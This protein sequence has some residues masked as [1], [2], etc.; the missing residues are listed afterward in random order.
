M[1]LF[2]T[3][4]SGLITARIA[5]NTTSNNIS[6]VYTP[7]YNRELTLV[8]EQRGDGGVRVSDVQRQFNQYVAAQLN[9]A[10]STHAALTGY[11]TQVNQINNLLADESVGL[12]ALMQNFFSSLQD[13]ASAPADPAARQGVIGAAD[14][15]SA[16]FRSLQG[17]MQ[18]MQDGINGQI[19]DEVTQ[20]NSLSRQ[21]AGLNREISLAAARNG[22]APNALLNQRDYLVSQLSQRLDVRL[23]VQDGGTYNLNLPNGQPM[24]TGSSHFEL[25]TR[26]S[27]ADPTRVI[28]AYRDAGGN[29]IELPEAA[30]AGG[31]LGG[32]MQFRSETLDGVQN[33][34]GLMAAALAGGFNAQHEAG[35]DL[36]GDP[37]QAFFDLG[38]PQVF[39]NVRNGGTA[40]ITAVFDDTVALTGA[41]YDLRVSDAASGE[42]V[43]TRR[44]SGE[45]FTA[46][47][48]AGG[49]LTVD[50]V[51]L[52]VDDPA[53]LV[54]GDRFQLQPTRRAASDFANLIH[55]TGLIAAGQG[56]GVGDNR[57][58]LAL[59][60]LQSAKLVGG[61]ASLNQTYAALVSEV[62]NRTNIVQARL[63]AQ[64]SLVEQVATLQQSES[65]VNLDEEA[66]NLIRYQQ[67]YQANAKVI[68]TASTLLDTILGL[69]G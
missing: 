63:A 27:N 18:D 62:G 5:L 36:L 1:S 65:G 41:D 31:S 54:D 53:L 56:G 19:R 17:Y 34:I 8:E 2:S 67:Y 57:N 58:A 3:G 40:Q 13:L 46:T 45:S 11:Q 16:Q 68:D 50:G 10:T 30:L 64:E 14:T 42:F 61:G 25:E 51:L 20:I 37:G 43:V 33:R 55:D 4:I 66:A 28:V 26:T 39:A 9:S 12:T 49:N 15:L 24:V 6:N 52:T 22:E 23:S 44:D 69:R 47:L 48:D 59:Q 21:L 60:D 35:V 38:S 7:G 32:L 29:S